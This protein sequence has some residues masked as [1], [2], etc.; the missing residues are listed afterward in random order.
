MDLYRTFFFF[1]VVPTVSLMYRKWK[2]YYLGI[3]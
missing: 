1:L 2:K 3:L